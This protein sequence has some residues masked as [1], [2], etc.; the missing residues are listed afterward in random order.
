MEV[1]IRGP[2]AK[3]N[4]T[5]SDGSLTMTRKVEQGGKIPDLTRPMSRIREPRAGIT[6]LFEEGVH[7]SINSGQAFCRGIFE[8][9]G[10]QV[11]GIR[12][13]LAENLVERVRLDLGELVLHIIRV[14]SSNLFAGRS[15]QDL[16]DLDKLINA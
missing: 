11:D 9:P 7:H 8:Q 2:L 4:N 6:E 1:S 10:D 5:K 16:D 14:H 12:V 15:P 13:R 3:T